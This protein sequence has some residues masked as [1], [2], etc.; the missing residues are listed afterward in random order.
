MRN[1]NGVDA[2]LSIRWLPYRHVAFNHLIQKEES[3]NKDLKIKK[4]RPN[5]IRLS[6]PLLSFTANRKDF[7]Y[8]LRTDVFFACPNVHYLTILGTKLY[9]SHRQRKLAF[10]QF[11]VIAICADTIRKLIM[12]I[13]EFLYNLNLTQKAVT[14]YWHVINLMDRNYTLLLHQSSLLNPERTSVSAELS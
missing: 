9:L 13:V 3:N 5:L 2:I 4:L 6:I 14:F 12:L 1:A 7:S 8:I 10:L 11:T